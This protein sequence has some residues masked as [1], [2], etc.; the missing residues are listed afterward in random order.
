VTSFSEV[1]ISRGRNKIRC[2]NTWKVCASLLFFSISIYCYLLYFNSELPFLVHQFPKAKFI[3]LKIYHIECVTNSGYFYY[4]F[5]VQQYCITVTENPN[6]I[7]AQYSFL[8]IFRST[9]FGQING[10]SYWNHMQRYF[11]LELFHVITTVVFII[12]KIGL[13]LKYSWN[14]IKS[15]YSVKLK[16]SINWYFVSKRLCFRFFI[17][18]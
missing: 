9:R 2:Y 17:L 14:I 16:K 5:S 1:L 12:I 4:T 6:Q 8:F 13:Q 18:M 10:T 7:F 11:N 15:V 3:R